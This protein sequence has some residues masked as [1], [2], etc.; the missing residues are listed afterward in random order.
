MDNSGLGITLE[1]V[2]SDGELIK[3][4]AEIHYY[5]WG[6]EPTGCVTVGRYVDGE[7][8]PMG[9]RPHSYATIRLKATHHNPHP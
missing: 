6:N 1:V 4:G 8:T 7:W 2:Q 5:E 3:T 9:I